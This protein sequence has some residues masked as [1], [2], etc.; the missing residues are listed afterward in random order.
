MMRRSLDFKGDGVRPPA[1]TSDADTA[2]HHRLW[3][4]VIRVSNV[5]A[6]HD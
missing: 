3:P 1:A 6:R 5:N 4:G 2:T